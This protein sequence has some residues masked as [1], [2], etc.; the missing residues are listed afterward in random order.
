[1]GCVCRPK[2]ELHE[3][4]HESSLWLE[5]LRPLISMEDL[6]RI[7]ALEDRLALWDNHADSF[8]GRAYDY[9][10]LVSD[11]YH[12]LKRLTGSNMIENPS[13]AFLESANE[14]EELLSEFL[15]YGG[16][17]ERRSACIAAVQELGELLAVIY[18]IFEGEKP[19]S[20][21]L[22]ESIYLDLEAYSL[23]DS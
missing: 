10:S 2:N 14:F 23:L 15:N 5:S 7:S 17:A 18:Q 6:S 12:E 11:S 1:M 16:T 9:L 13:T 22:L 8:Y 19:V 21:E 4:R 3:I 20:Y